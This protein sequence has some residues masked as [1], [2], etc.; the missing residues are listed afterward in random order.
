M[1][2]GIFEIHFYELLITKNEGRNGDFF[3]KLRKSEKM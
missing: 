2:S 3:K 1:V